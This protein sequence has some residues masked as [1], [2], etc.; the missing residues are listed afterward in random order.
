MSACPRSSACAWRT[1]TD[2]TG[3]ALRLRARSGNSPSDDAGCHN[4][5]DSLLVCFFTT[6]D[7][8]FKNNGGV[9]PYLV[10]NR[11]E[12]GR[13]ERVWW[14]RLAFDNLYNIILMVSLE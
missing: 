6:F 1:C 8:G 9:G 13:N 3:R 7:E 12:P 14:A 4:Q 5:C 10:P 2:L 11:L